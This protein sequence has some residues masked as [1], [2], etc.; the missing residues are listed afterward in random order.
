MHWTCTSVAA[1]SLAHG[2]T[3]MHVQVWVVPELREC[4]VLL[5]S[6]CDVFPMLFFSSNL[7]FSQ[8]AIQQP[9]IQLAHLL[10]PAMSYMH[11]MCCPPVQVRTAGC[12]GVQTLTASSLKGW[13]LCW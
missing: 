1:V 13:R 8:Q 3:Y 5:R 12:T 4:R 11:P 6:T 9:R 7:P 2:V 10:L